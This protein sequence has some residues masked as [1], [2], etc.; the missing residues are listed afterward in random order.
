MRAEP[1]PSMAPLEKV[2]PLQPAA[3]QI[4]KLS[5]YMIDA[6][7]PQTLPAEMGDGEDGFMSISLLTKPESL[8]N[9]LA[10]EA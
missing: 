1:A 4:Q 9:H 6:E 2:L 10:V 3:Q 8:S 5:G 7:S